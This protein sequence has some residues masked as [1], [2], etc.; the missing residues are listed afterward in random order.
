MYEL[1][2]TEKHYFIQACNFI[3]LPREYDFSK[4]YFKRDKAD[5]HILKTYFKVVITKPCT[6]LH[7]APPSSVHLHPAH[8]KLYPPPTTSTQLISASIQLSTLPSTLLESKYLTQLGNFPKLRPKHLELS[9][10]TENLH[11]YFR[12]QT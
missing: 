4:F 12:I 8:F 10:L 5:A 11:S 3:N 7:P 9:I 2:I 1:S 6:C